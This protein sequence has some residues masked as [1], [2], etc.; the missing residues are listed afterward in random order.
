MKLGKLK[1][2]RLGWSWVTTLLCT[3]VIVTAISA[4]QAL[5]LA[6]IAV[7]DVEKASVERVVDGDTIVVCR[8]DGTSAKVRL[9]GA[10]TPESVH[11]DASRNTE[12]GKD[13]SEHVEKALPAGTAVW[14][15]KDVSET[16]RYGRLLR[17]VWTAD[18]ASEGTSFPADC[19]NARL[20][21]E[22]WAEAKDYPPDTRRS[23][24]LHA[25][26]KEER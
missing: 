5:P 24:E 20:V 26:K 3:A 13:A 25:L 8:G 12:A 16:D 9:I 23:A 1:R 4:A 7:E 21:A 10:D 11:P 6:S 17:Y 19:L 14:L 2:I 22:G 15:E 18:P